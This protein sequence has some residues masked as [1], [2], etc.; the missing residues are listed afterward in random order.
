MCARL[1]EATE[2][3][4]D[5]LE[6]I[7]GDSFRRIGSL[8]LAV[9]EEERDELR[10]EFELLREDGFAAE[11]VDVF[12]EPL[13]GRYT[14]AIRHVPDGVLQPA[15]FVR[16]L[17]GAAAGAGAE[18]REFSRIDSIARRGRASRRGGDRRLSERAPR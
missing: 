8:R 18:F 14:G 7:A 17:A 10:A 4:L 5:R 11:W 6:A 12:D 2:A 15:R 1:W 16:R 3:A 13:A 9:D